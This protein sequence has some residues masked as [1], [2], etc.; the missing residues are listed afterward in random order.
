MNVYIVRHI[1]Y[2]KEILTAHSTLQHARASVKMRM[3]QAGRE[4][5]ATIYE[6]TLDD[7]HVIDERGRMNEAIEGQDTLF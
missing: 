5:R 2:G 1:I 4:H 7:L 6:G 3:R